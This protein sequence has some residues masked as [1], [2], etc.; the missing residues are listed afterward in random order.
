MRIIGT[1]VGV[2]CDP[3]PNI[4]A[5]LITQIIYGFVVLPQ[6]WQNELTGAKAVSKAFSTFEN[7]LI[8]TF[9]SMLFTLV[10]RSIGNMSQFTDENFNL[11]NRIHDGVIVLGE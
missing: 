11:L 5:S 7:F 3:A 1:F 4:L 8:L 2:A 10:V 9:I 6:V